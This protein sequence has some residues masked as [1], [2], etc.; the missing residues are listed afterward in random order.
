[1]LLIAVASA[2]MLL[3]CSLRLPRIIQFRLSS[4]LLLHRLFE[5]IGALLRRAASYRM[6][7]CMYRCHLKSITC[8][9]EGHL[10]EP[11]ACGSRRRSCTYTTKGLK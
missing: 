4:L 9:A 8:A 2:E 11:P 5:V 6:Y 10:P 7:P 3:I 1:M